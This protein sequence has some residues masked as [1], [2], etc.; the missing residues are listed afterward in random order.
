MYL[1][2]EEIQDL[3]SLEKWLHGAYHS[4]LDKILPGPK[5]TAYYEGVTGAAKSGFS[6]TW[7]LTRRHSMQSMGLNFMMRW[8]M[9]DFLFHEY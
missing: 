8:L 9:K 3:V 4:G 7:L 2:G 5:G 1:G 6:R